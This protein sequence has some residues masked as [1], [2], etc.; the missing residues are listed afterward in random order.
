[1]EGLAREDIG[2][3]M[4]I[5][6]IL[7]PKGICFGHLVHLV[8]IWYI[9]WSFGIFLPGLVC[10]TEKNLATLI[11]KRR[12]RVFRKIVSPFSLIRVFFGRRSGLPDLVCLQTKNPNLGKFWSTLEWKM[13]IHFWSFEIFYGH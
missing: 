6:S 5:S 7:L 11:W 10:C 9:W 8:V 2:I 12:I 3:F 1:L 13:L 4:S